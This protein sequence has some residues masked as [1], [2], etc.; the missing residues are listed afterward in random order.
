MHYSKTQ[1]PAIVLFCRNIFLITACGFI[2]S[3]MGCN[4][5]NK[6]N[7]STSDSLDIS[8]K[9]APVKYPVKDINMLLDSPKL[10]HFILQ[11]VS[12]TGS[13]QDPFTLVSYARDSTG[14]FINTAGYNLEPLDT[15]NP[16]TFNGKMTLGNLRVSRASIDSLLTTKKGQ[17][18][19]DGY[20]LFTPKLDNDYIFYNIVVQGSSISN[21][22]NL[23]KITRARPCPPA[24]NCPAKPTP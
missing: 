4:Q 23:I 2:L 9:F 24:I 12:P 15:L 5:T 14:G 20:L 11:Y 18:I 22:S 21:D 7:L 19:K 8:I 13:Y 17:R 3:F 6:S 10:N 16:K 1:F